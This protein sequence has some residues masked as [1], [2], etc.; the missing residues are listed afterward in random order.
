[1]GKE[2]KIVSKG[3]EP[4]FSFLQGVPGRA[5]GGIRIPN[6]PNSAEIGEYVRVRFLSVDAEGG[7]IWEYVRQ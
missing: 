1:M 6:L 7:E 4:L 5:E 2:V 3:V